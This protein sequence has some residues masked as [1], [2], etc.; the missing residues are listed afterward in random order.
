MPDSGPRTV[1]DHAKG[2]LT[3]VRPRRNGDLIPRPEN[4][5]ENGRGDFVNK[6]AEGN[7]EGLK[8]VRVENPDGWDV[9]V[10]TTSD[11][12]RQNSAPLLIT[13]PSFVDDRP[14]VNGPPAPSPNDELLARIPQA[15]TPLLKVVKAA[16][17]GFPGT[18][19]EKPMWYENCWIKNGNLT[20][21]SPPVPF[22]V[23]N[24]QGVT[25]TWEDPPPGVDGVALFFS[26]P[27]TSSATSPGPMREQERLF[28]AT[29]KLSSR[30]LSGPYRNG[31]LAPTFNETMF[32]APTP[33]PD[34]EIQNDNYVV[35]KP[36]GYLV[37]GEYHFYLTLADSQGQGQGETP[38]S[39]VYHVEV[40]NSTLT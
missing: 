14:L 5:M 37:N 4:S 38:A 21:P 7:P 12:R 33:P 24:G 39:L 27:G 11:V 6:D 35:F 2:I 34:T 13:R 9:L 29:Y 22:Q 17:H 18:T 26:E 36:G 8:I 1:A 28:F 20:T 23:A 19:P 32:S 15:Q 25:V 10:G 40:T 30:E 3:N 16:I 31:R